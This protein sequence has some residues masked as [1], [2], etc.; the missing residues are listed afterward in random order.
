MKEQELKPIKSSLKLV[1][2]PAQVFR[3]LTSQNELR[4]WWAPKVIIARNIVSQEEDRIME[5]R[6]MQSEPNDLVRYSWRGN[7][8]DK[9]L[10]NTVITFQIEDLGA[11]R[12]KTGEGLRLTISHDGWQDAEERDHQELVWKKA[13]PA[14]RALLAGKSKK[15]WWE[16]TEARGS[17]RQVK[18]AILK[19]IV[20]SIEKNP[21]IKTSKKILQCVW[22][23]C[24]SLD[25]FGNWYLKNDDSKYELR[26]ENI[27]IFSITAEGYVSLFWADIKNMLGPNM[28]DV[29]NRFIVEQ[30]EDVIIGKTQQNVRADKLHLDIW[31]QWCQDFLTLAKNLKG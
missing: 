18:M 12:S 5:M 10:P 2:T 24:T 31:I 28:E 21:P 9:M 26:V 11:S 23:I 22:K 20:E 14:L 4:K 17:Y 25:E 3:A 16:G 8:W 1:A 13:L 6:L 29:I 19:P 30:D 7:E 15:P 27:R